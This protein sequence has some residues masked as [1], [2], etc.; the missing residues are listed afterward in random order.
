[1]DEGVCIA[2]ELAGLL[3]GGITRAVCVGSAPPIAGAA[4]C[5]GPRIVVCTRQRHRMTV[6]GGQTVSLGRG[7]ALLMAPGGWNKALPGQRRRYCS[8]TLQADGLRCFLRHHDGCGLDT[9]PMWYRLLPPPAADD[10][11]LW[12]LL[13]G[14]EE[15][16]RPALVEAVLWRCLAQL[17]AAPADEPQARR[18]WQG[19]AAWLDEQLPRLP[20]REATAT[21]HGLHPGYVSQLFHDHAGMSFQDWCTTRRLDHARLLLREHP[22]L[23]VGEVAAICDYG[24]ARYFRRMYKR[25]FGRSPTQDR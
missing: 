5:L 13:M 14:A 8:F 3:Y 11:A 9:S 17:R 19:I 4:V 18:R 16:A 22:G 23:P 20:G 21:H 7:E 15:A 2:G 12:R 10:Q 6:P 24:D 25:R 1:M